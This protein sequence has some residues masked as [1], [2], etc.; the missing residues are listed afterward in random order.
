MVESYHGWIVERGSLRFVAWQLSGYDAIEPFKGPWRVGESIKVLALAIDALAPDRN[1]SSD[2]TKGNEA[3]QTYRSDHN[4]WVKDGTTGVVTA[5]DITH[6]PDGGADMGAITERVRLARH[7]VVK[8]VIHASKIFAS[9]HR[10]H[11]PAWEWG[12]YTGSSPHT[13]HAH[14]SVLS[15][16]FD[17]TTPWPLTEEEGDDMA[18]FVDSITAITWHQMGR[19]FPE[20]PNFG[21]YY[22]P[23]GGVEA[24]AD[25]TASRVNAYNVWM[26]RLSARDNTLPPHSH[27]LPAHNHVLPAHSHNVSGKAT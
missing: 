27:P 21:S 15:D 25:P 8:Y 17:D 20:D 6:D 18:T 24:E 16:N 7:P 2:G 26:Q 13:H 1:R 9:Y 5:I 4:P 14:F 11:R 23:G 3:H 22:S 10:D 19:L 12:P